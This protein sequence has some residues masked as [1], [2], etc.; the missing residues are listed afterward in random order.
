MTPMSRLKIKTGESQSRKPLPDGTYAAKIT[1]LQDEKQGPKASYVPV[2]FTI[3]EGEHEGRKFYS[4]FMT[5]GAAAGMFIDLINKATG[6]TYD[7][8]EI[9]R[10]ESELDLDPN[11]L[12]G[13]EVAIVLKQEEYPEDSGNWSSKIKGVLKAKGTKAAAASGDASEAPRRSRRG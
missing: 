9:N 7:V 1:D 12:I 10:G 5:D 4:N 11:D 13:C 3:S 8:D 6:S 2:E